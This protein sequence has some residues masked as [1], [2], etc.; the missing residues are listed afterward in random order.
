MRIF[1]GGMKCFSLGKAQPGCLG[2]LVLLLLAAAWL[3]KSLGPPAAQGEPGL[4]DDRQQ[5]AAAI[6]HAE[7]LR[8]NWQQVLA[9]LNNAF[10]EVKAADHADQGLERFVSARNAAIKDLDDL[11][12]QAA[13]AVVKLE[14]KQ[15]YFAD[16]HVQSLLPA[17]VL[18]ELDDALRLQLQ[19]LKS[20]RAEVH[21]TQTQLLPDIHSRLKRLHAACDLKAQ[22][23]GL[24][25]AR[26]L[27]HSE[28][29]Q[30]ADL[31]A[32]H[33]AQ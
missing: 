16:P 6:S 11:L 22:I 3:F 28:S 33:P 32:V 4:A 13:D 18:P 29:A 31:T 15:A 21:T 2:A 27:W 19:N 5:A 24:Q 25:A 17:E 7:A 10:T 23:S 30:I 9:Q 12:T 20:L 14:E 8:L 26:E 1:L